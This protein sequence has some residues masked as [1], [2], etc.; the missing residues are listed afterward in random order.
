MRSLEYNHSQGETVDED[1]ELFIKTELKKERYM[2]Y[3]RRFSITWNVI[4]SLFSFITLFLFLYQT[5][6]YL[7]E[8]AAI[9]L[10]FSLNLFIEGA[11]IID[12]I[13]NL[14]KPVLIRGE[15]ITGFK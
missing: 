14:F 12:V 15:V 4:L 8:D 9:T 13:V 2:K 10:V 6:F 1:S 3:E 5:G 7:K 11:F